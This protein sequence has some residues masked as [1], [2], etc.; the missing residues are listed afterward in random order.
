MANVA[1][2]IAK[3]FCVSIDGRLASTSSELS[4]VQ[5]CLHRTEGEILRLLEDP[6]ASPL[7][8]AASLC[9][10]QAR[11][12]GRP[13]V[14]A[15]DGCVNELHSSLL[16]F[17]LH[18]AKVFFLGK[19]FGDHCHFQLFHGHHGTMIVLYAPLKE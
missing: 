3:R 5:S 7:Q 13:H 2:S 4:A 14:Q 12:I 16:V 17:L 19:D 6:D 1:A 8:V 9:H 11:V 15:R 10:E 18:H